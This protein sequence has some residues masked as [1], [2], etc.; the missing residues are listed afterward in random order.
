MHVI[1]SVATPVNNRAKS[2]AINLMRE[3]EV[4]GKLLCPIIVLPL[5][6]LSRPDSQCFSLT[7]PRP[8]SPKPLNPKPPPRACREVPQ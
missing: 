3:Y 2:M 8:P 7:A 4:A 1:R 6:C 5:I